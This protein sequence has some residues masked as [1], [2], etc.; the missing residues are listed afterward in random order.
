MPLRHDPEF[1]PDYRHATYVRFRMIDGPFWV[2]VRVST[3]TIV[4]LAHRDRMDNEAISA[5]FRRYR[6]KIE[7]AASIRYDKLSEK[8]G[9]IVVLSYDL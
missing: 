3:R 9:D 8:G 7:Q 2:F 1:Q 4:D 6:D 5:L